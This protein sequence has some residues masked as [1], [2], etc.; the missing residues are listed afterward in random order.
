MTRMNKNENVEI[1]SLIWFKPGVD[2]ERILRW[3]AKLEEKDV[4]RGHSTQEYNPEHGFP[5]WY[6]P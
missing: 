4:I 2:R 1:A 6:I 3:I 5:V